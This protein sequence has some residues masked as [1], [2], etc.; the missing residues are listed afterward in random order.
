MGTYPPLSQLCVRV[1]LLK[2]RTTSATQSNGLSAPLAPPR[3]ESVHS[4]LLGAAQQVWAW[5]EEHSATG[6]APASWCS[7]LLFGACSAAHTVQRLSHE[8]L[9]H[10]PE[11]LQQSDRKRAVF[12]R[13]ATHPV[14]YCPRCSASS[15]CSTPVT[16]HCARPHRRVLCSLGLFSLACVAL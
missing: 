4:Q 8:Q 15:G 1:D 2:L 10:G 6:P 12:V 7:G 3:S 11:G 16:N 14:Q 9:T 13:L 5:S